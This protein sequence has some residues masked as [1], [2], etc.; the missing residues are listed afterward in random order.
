MP[1]YKQIE[2]K[3]DMEKK[4]DAL[5]RVKKILNFQNFHFL[6]KNF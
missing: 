2:D 1:F 6:K 5:K 4:G 3:F